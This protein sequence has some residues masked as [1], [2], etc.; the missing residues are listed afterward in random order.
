MAQLEAL[1]ICNFCKK[2]NTITMPTVPKFNDRFHEQCVQCEKRQILRFDH[3]VSSNGNIKISLRHTSGKSPEGI[4][5]HYS[6][7]IVT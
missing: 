4:E 7:E 6:G 1:F 2:L 5:G 3:T